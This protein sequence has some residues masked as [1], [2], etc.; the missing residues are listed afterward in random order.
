M[1]DIADKTESHRISGVKSAAVLLLSL[2]LCGIVAGFG[3]M[4]T[5][6][7]VGGWYSTIR[8]PSWTPPDW[9]FG[10]VWTCLYIMMAVAAWLVWKRWANWKR[11]AVYIFQLALNCL[12][13]PIFFGLH[14]IGLSCIIIVLLELSI[15]ATILMFWPVSRAAALML[16]PYLLWVGFA[17]FLNI[18]IWRLNVQ[19]M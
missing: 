10:P 6:E 1:T 7:G 5:V 18:E 13:T 12:W 3:A 9:L 2:V 11:L 19:T 15:T 4:F 17:C 16:T 8:R 14:L